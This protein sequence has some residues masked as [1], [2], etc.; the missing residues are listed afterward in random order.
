MAVTNLPCEFAADASRQFCA[1]MGTLIEGVAAA[2]FAAASPA[3]A[4][5][6]EPI[7]RAVILWQGKFMPD[8]AYMKEFLAS[9]K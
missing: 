3:A 5:L 2:D 7:Q 6:P 9:D 1:D 4:G 8:Y